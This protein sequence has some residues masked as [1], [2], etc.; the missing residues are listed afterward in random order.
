LALV[1][2]IAEAHGGKV[3]V[4]SKV[5]EGSKFTLLLPTD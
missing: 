4:E 1:E 5:G 3:A 2:Y